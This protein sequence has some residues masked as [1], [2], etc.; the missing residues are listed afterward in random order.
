[1]L[2]QILDFEY[3]A[4]GSFC[5]NMPSLPSLTANT[6]HNDREVWKKT[7]GRVNFTWSQFCSKCDTIVRF[8]T[9]T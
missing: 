3:D 4:N 6:K 7:F 2:Q 5:V 1:M 8:V 9:V